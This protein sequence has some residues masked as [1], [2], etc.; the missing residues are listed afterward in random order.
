[1]GRDGLRLWYDS[2]TLTSISMKKLAFQRHFF[3]S[4]VVFLLAGTLHFVRL[5]AGWELILDAWVVPTWLSVLAVVVTWGLSLHG[6]CAAKKV[7]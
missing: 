3:W 4:S 1:M 2:F 6:F 5:V 7:K